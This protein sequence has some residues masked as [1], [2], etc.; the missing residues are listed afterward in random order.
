MDFLTEKPQPG[1]EQ[2][3]PISEYQGLDFKRIGMEKSQYQ[4][5]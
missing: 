2:I 5:V 4:Q 1:D 3:M